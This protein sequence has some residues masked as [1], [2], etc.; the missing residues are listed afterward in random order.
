[1]RSLYALFLTGALIL[2]T[3]C[4]A[5]R[6]VSVSTP[7]EN[8]APAAPAGGPALTGN[9][10][11]VSVALRIYEREGTRWLEPPQAVYVEQMSYADVHKMLPMSGDPQESGWAAETLMWM[12]VFR[13]QWRLL[14]YG[15]TQ[16]APAPTI[17]KGCTF[18]VFTAAADEV[19]MAGDTPCPGQQ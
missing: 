2:A 11:A 7:V 17:Y 10:E 13:G 8:A 15:Q 5:P 1:M 16:G 3:G 18:V 4:S 14:P 6:S 12:V 19:I 9:S